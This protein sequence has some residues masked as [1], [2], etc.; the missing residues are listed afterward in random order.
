MISAF[1]LTNNR[2][3][4]Q[5]PEI[6]KVRKHKTADDHEGRACEEDLPPPDSVSDHRKEDP[7]E[8]ISE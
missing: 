1:T 2:R 3:N 7:Q 4:K 8:D 5:N 6:L